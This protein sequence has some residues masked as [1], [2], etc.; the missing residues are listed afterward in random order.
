[1]VNVGTIRNTGIDLMITQRG[2]IAGEID[3]ELSANFS[4]TRMRF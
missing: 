4:A 2:K 3:Y 1:M